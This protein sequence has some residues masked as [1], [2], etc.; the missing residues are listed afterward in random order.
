MDRV[1]GVALHDTVGADAGGGAA[2]EVI[3]LGAVEVLAVKAGAVDVGAGFASV[4]G[5]VVVNGVAVDAGVV[6]VVKAD[7]ID[8]GVA[9]VAE[10]LESGAITAVAVVVVDVVT[11]TCCDTISDDPA[12]ASFSASRDAAGDIVCLLALAVVVVELDDVVDLIR[13]SPSCIYSG[14]EPFEPPDVV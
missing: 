13:A 12:D 9:T 7:A 3:V 1:D 2:I 14:P 6:V 10:V 5:L 8:I 4:E 11:V